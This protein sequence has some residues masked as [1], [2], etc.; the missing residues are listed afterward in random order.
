MSEVSQGPGWWVASD[1]KWY[2]PEQHPS[3]RQAVASPMATTAPR[4]AAA[5]P[6]S[7]AVYDSE[8]V[9]DVPG[10][11]PPSSAA[12]PPD[13]PSY[14]S[15]DQRGQ[16][17]AG[18]EGPAR[19]ANIPAPPPVIIPQVRTPLR[20]PATVAGLPP[21]SGVPLSNGPS[22][23][24]PGQPVAGPAGGYGGTRAPLSPFE[25]GV[26]SGA[27]LTQRRRKRRWPIWWAVIFVM[28]AVGATLGTLYYLKNSNPHRSAVAIAEDYL[29]AV[30]NNSKSQEKADVLPGQ[31]PVTAGFDESG[32]SFDVTSTTTVGMD[33]MVNLLVCSGLYSGASCSSTIDG[34]AAGFVPTREVDGKWYVDASAFPICQSKVETLVCVLPVS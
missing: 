4:S 11:A 29:V 19:P 6:S 27:A 1:G 21:P 26:Y 20:R 3:V 28:V 8:F 10:A 18:T 24:A 13:L 9:G 33:R 22:P 17:G 23:S 32:L 25:E 30:S 7:H 16:A 31:Q 14:W 12:P 34:S 5:P 15:G 2:P